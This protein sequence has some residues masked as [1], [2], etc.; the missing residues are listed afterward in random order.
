VEFSTLES[1]IF[2]DL[3]SKHHVTESHRADAQI[4]ATLLLAPAWEN[5]T[6]HLKKVRMERGFLGWTFTRVPRKHAQTEKL[7]DLTF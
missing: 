1:P 6:R 4:S 5:M 3:Q 2:G 7:E